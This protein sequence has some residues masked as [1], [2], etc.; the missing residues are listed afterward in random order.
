MNLYIVVK[1]KQILKTSLF[2][3]V[4][5][6]LL[7]LPSNNMTSVSA[8]VDIFKNNVFPSLFPFILF[9]EIIMHTSII[10]IL[11]KRLG[12]LFEVLFKVP[13]IASSA[14]IIGFL[15]GFPMGAKAINELYESSK[16]SKKSAYFLLKFTNN[17]NPAF[18][19][20]T[21]GIALFKS[22]NVGVLILVSHYLSS[23]LIGFFSNH[24]DDSIIIQE[25]ACKLKSF[26]KKI[27][28][29]RENEKI[30]FEKNDKNK[31]NKADGN[32]NLVGLVKRSILNTFKSLALIFGFII[33]FNL[34]YSCLE[35][36][37]DALNVNSKIKVLISAIMEMTT[38]SK[39]IASSDFPLEAKLCLVSFTLGFSGLSIIAQ[40]SSSVSKHN[41]SLL[42]IIKYKFIHGILSF[43][44]TYIL[45][46]VKNIFK[47][48]YLSLLL[49]IVLMLLLYFLFYIVFFK[50][51]KIKQ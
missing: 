18:I 31:A 14:V 37:L 22:I 15:C 43:F 3:I 23:A 49:V 33:I 13:A 28:F 47:V 51:K 5:S 10:D 24:L 44:I 42:S 48:D 8:S 4:L 27:K 17:C 40:I 16:I 21:V 1:L 50:G 38:G 41:F 34:I 9:T 30:Y 39:N 11:S 29:L 6:I 12:K 35:I 2:I 7:M 26:D 46:N 32:I 20:S 25:K 45:I 36:F 19:I